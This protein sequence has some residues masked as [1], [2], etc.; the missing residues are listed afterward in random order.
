MTDPVVDTALI[1]V[2]DKRGLVEFAAARAGRGVTLLSTGG[3]A[4]RLAA[5]GIAVREVSDYTGFPEMMGGRIKTLHPKVHGGILGRRGVDDQ[6]IAAHDIRPIGLVVVNL[7]PFAETVAKP[8]C[9]LAAAIENIDIGGPAMVR[10]AAKNFHAAGVV[11][12]PQD[13]GRV[14]AELEQNQGALGAQLRFELAA[15]A[16]AHTARY[17]G[18]IANYLGARE[19]GASLFPRTLNLQLELTGEMRYGENPHQR[20]ALYRGG[21]A[22]AVNVVNAV[23]VQGK[24]CLLYTSPSPRDATL[25]RMPSSA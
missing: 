16:F 11:V 6:V 21:A 2:A 12:S 15:K 19:R 8:D 17:D 10:A 1:S 22:A 23:Q 25:S 24:A 13:Y 14:L 18:M 3:T 7:Y 20:G 4:R 9:D 5:A